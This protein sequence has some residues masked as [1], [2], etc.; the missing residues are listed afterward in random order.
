MPYDLFRYTAP[1]IRSLNTTDSGVYFSIDG[2]HTNLKGFNP[3]GNGGDL[4]DWAD[5]QGPDAYN[6]FTSSGIENGFSSVDITAMDVIGYDALV[7]GDFNRDGHVD[8]ADITAMESALANLHGYETTNNLTNQQLLVIGDLN[9]DA[10]NLAVA[11][12][13]SRSFLHRKNYP[14]CPS[15][16]CATAVSACLR[17][18]IS[19]T[20]AG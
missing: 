11:M 5:D 2:G 18:D 1:E 12:R 15:S 4:Q 3:P 6:A 8:T 20:R 16:S 9:G 17:W 13:M 7:R 10:V 19:A 14:R